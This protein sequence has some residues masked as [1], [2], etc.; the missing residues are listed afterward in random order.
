MHWRYELRKRELLAECAVGPEV[1]D[2]AAERLAEF[3]RPFAA[4]LARREQRGHA[5]TSLAGLVSDLGRKDTESI[6]YRHG[7]ER[8]GCSTSSAPRPGATGP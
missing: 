4:A 6:A 2:G 7:Q 5:R 3:A 1:F 8:T